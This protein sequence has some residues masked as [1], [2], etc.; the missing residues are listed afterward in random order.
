MLGLYPIAVPS[1]SHPGVDRALSLNEPE[2]IPC[3]THILSP[4]GWLRGNNSRHYAINA[5]SL[6]SLTHSFE[7]PGEYKDLNTCKHPLEVQYLKYLILY[8]FRNM[9]A[10][11]NQGAL[12]GP[13][14]T[15]RGAEHP[16][17]WRVATAA[18]P[19]ALGLWGRFGCSTGA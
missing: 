9:G 11:K 2:Y 15:S 6:R 1:Y 10:S 17:D 8:L 12:K 14:S 19:L 5:H 16:R 18:A 3:V 7:E 13:Y 4:S